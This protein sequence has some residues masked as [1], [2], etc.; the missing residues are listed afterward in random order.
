MSVLAV[1]KS[2]KISPRKVSQ[3]ASLV[4]GR[5]V[6][7][8]LTILSYTNRRGAKAV[9]DVIKSAS[10]N[11]THNHGYKQEG[12]FISEITVNHGPSLKRF[13]PVARGMAHPFQHQTSH[14]RVSVDGQL[15][16]SAAKKKESVAKPKTAKETK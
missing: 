1:A 6:S 5:T 7:D 15:R 12:L 13:R 10:A 2:V 9:F 8:A 4:R 16:Q 14:I 11:A 3:V